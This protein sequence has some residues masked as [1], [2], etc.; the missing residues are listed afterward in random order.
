MDF[1]LGKQF[2][3]N[4]LKPLLLQVTAFFTESLQ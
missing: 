2:F 4:A 3:V 1:L